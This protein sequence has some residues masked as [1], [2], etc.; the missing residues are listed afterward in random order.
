MKV[1]FEKRFA[2]V[3][4]AA[5]VALGASPAGALGGGDGQQQ[6]DGGRSAINGTQLSGVRQG[7][8]INGTKLTGVREPNSATCSPLVCGTTGNGTKLTGVR[9]PNA[10]IWQNGTKL[11]GVREPNALGAAAELAE[12]RLTVVPTR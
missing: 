1:R 9:E 5:V 2:A 10:G 6:G 11:T 4:F 12:I 8:D 7:K 3:A